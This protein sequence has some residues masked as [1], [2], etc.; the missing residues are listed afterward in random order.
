MVGNA[1]GFRSHGVISFEVSS[2]SSGTVALLKHI[3]VKYWKSGIIWSWLPDHVANLQYDWER[4][5]FG[6]VVDSAL[7]QMKLC[8]SIWRL[9]DQ[10]I[11]VKERQIQICIKPQISLN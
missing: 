10:M 3:V 1:K 11:A 6:C 9:S 8:S 2:S 4:L 5:S 7:C